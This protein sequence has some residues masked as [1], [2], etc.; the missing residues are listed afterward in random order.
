MPSTQEWNDRQRVQWTSASKGWE[1]RTAWLDDNIRDLTAWFCEAAHL[2]PGNRVLDV[3]C[4][5]GQPSLTAAKVV[6]PNGRVVATDIAQGMLEV[7]SRRASAAGLSNIEFRE[8]DAQSLDL[9]SS[10]F[11]AA[12]CSFGL[13]FCPDTRKALSEMHRVLRPAGRIAV[14]VWDVPGKNP[15]FTSISKPIEPYMPPSPPDP[16]APGVFRLAVPGL[17]ERMLRDAGFENV[18]V[19]SRPMAFEYASLED[20]WEIQTDIAAPL[21]AAVSKLAEPELLQLKAGVFTAIGSYVLD[22]RV[23]LPAAALCVTGDKPRVAS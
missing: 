13:M 3:A 20:Y 6:G 15:F 8:M 9:E 16:D 23:R 5:T 14:S 22:G 21:K 12:T 2:A 10:S 17:I 7:A 4:G 1:R 11:D 18:A 19:E